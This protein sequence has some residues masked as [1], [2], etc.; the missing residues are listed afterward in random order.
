MVIAVRV[1]ER[2][3]GWEADDPTFKVIL[4]EPAGTWSVDTYDLSGCGVLDAIRWAQDNSSPDGAWAVGLVT[5]RNDLADD[6]G[7]GFTYLEGYD[8]NAPLDELTSWQRTQIERM[9]GR[10]GKRAT[11]GPG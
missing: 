2:D 3:G 8:L 4:F 11:D 9:L 6:S 1:D 7:P 10:R 5:N